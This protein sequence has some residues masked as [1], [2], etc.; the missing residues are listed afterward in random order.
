MDSGINDLVK[1]YENTLNEF[2]DERNDQLAEEV[3][4]NQMRN[5]LD[6]RRDAILSN[7]LIKHTNNEELARS[8]AT[9][10]FSKYAQGTLYFNPKAINQ[11][12][13]YLCQYQEYADL[14]IDY[15]KFHEDDTGIKEV[16][17]DEL[18]IAREVITKFI[19]TPAFNDNERRS[20]S[21]SIKLDKRCIAMYRS[22]LSILKEN[23]EE[24]K[25]FNAVLKTI[26]EEVKSN[27]DTKAE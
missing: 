26:V 5:K 23:K 24:D 7:L 9:I 25:E 8:I 1:G 13:G 6:A 11:A 16:D 15:L 4:K 14:L 3:K 2:T 18:K 21:V 10:A 19:N 20:V 17:P 12:T 22:F 27:S